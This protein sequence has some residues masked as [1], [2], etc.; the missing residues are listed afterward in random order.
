MLTTQLHTN[1][2]AQGQKTG[3]HTGSAP[4]PASLLLGPALLMDCRH[5]GRSAC[6][7]SARQ[8]HLG[9]PAEPAGTRG[10]ESRTFSSTLFSTHRRKTCT[11]FFCPMRCALS[12]ACT[13]ACVS[14][15]VMHCWPLVCQAPSWQLPGCGT[16]VHQHGSSARRMHAPV[17]WSCSAA[18]SQPSLPHLDLTPL[19]G[20]PRRPV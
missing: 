4:A 11:S 7:A 18:Q 13:P 10:P 19:S 9:T 14:H 2:Q 3:S 20:C 17:A 16:A 6:Q 15:T 12:M 8:V 5:M 1:P